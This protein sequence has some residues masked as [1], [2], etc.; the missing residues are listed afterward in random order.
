MKETALKSQHESLGARMVPFVGWLMPVQYQGILD[1]V[2]MVRRQAGLFDLG[3]MGRVR[4]TGADAV[5]FLQRVQ[6]QDVAIIPNGGIRYAMILDR[7]GYIQDDVLVYRQE[8][9]AGF[10]LAVNAANTERDLQILRDAATGF[11][12]VV[13]TDQT[14]ELGMF[15]IQ[16]PLSQ[17][18]IQRITDID[19]SSLRYYRWTTGDVAGQR[20]EISRTGYTGEDGFE[21]CATQGVIPGLWAAVLEAGRGQGLAPAGLGARDTLRLEAGMALYGHEIDESTTPLEAGLAWAVKFT[22]DFL[23][24]KALERIQADGG[25]NRGLVGLTTKSRRVPRQGYPV[26]CDNQ[27][28]GKILS[29]AAS[30]TLETNIAT[31]YLPIELSEP[32]TSVAFAI[33]DKLEPATV[34][35]LPFYKR[36]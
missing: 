34:T 9:D 16:G 7:D 14:D 19:L 25:P 31:C 3:H 33:K 21:I 17:E 12:D 11:S 27:E 22:H 1:E 10:F 5:P 35:A 29:G 4:I 23:G 20:V 8:D 26:L 15:A 13:V 30:P 28:V 2:R 36:K 24:R 6:T 18:I 32:G